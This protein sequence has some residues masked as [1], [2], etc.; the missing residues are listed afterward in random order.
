MVSSQAL[1]AANSDM[2]FKYNNRSPGPKYPDKV[3][4]LKV[5]LDQGGTY[6]DTVLEY[7]NLLRMACM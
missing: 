4:V 5:I 7:K 1:A 3:T 6:M 2:W